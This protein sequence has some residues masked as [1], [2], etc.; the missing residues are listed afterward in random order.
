MKEETLNRL[1]DKACELLM[2]F[3]SGHTANEEDKQRISAIFDEIKYSEEID[4]EMELC[5]DC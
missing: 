2:K 3:E 5:K 4:K 1:L